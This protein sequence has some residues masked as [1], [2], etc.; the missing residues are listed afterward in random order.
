MAELKTAYRYIAESGSQRQSV[1]SARS[2]LAGMQD[3]PVPGQLVSKQRTGFSAPEITGEAMKRLIPTLITLTI[4]SAAFLFL[5]GRGSL[6]SASEPPVGLAGGP[7]GPKSAVNRPGIYIFQAGHVSPST[8]PG[9]FVGAHR[10]V[11]W[12]EIEVSPG[13]YNW[14][15]FDNWIAGEAAQGKPVALGVDGCTSGGNMAPAWIPKIL[16]GGRIIP[17]YWST[18]YRDGFR[19]LV[20][21][22]GERYNDDPRVEWVEISTGRDGENQP[23]LNDD[24]DKCLLGLGYT[25]EDWVAVVTEIVGYYR[26]AFPDK[27][28]MTQHYPKFDWHHERERRDIANYAAVLGVGFKG[29]GLTP[30]RDKMVCRLPSYTYGY[31]SFLEDPIISYS[32]TLPIG[33]ESYRFYLSQDVHVYWAL[34]SALDS[35]AD[36]IALADDVFT[37]NYGGNSLWPILQFT[38]AHVGRTSANTPSAWVALR[39]SGYSY[40]PKIGNYSYY[41]YQD[42]S[43]SAGRTQAITYRPAG[44]GPYEIQRGDV[45]AGQTYL[46]TWWQSWTTRRTDQASGNTYMYFDIDNR[47]LYGAT[48]PV[49]LTVTYYDHVFGAGP[50]TWLLEYDSDTGIKSAGHAIS[51][52]GTDEWIQKTFYL[53]DANFQNTM[54]GGKADF[55]ISCQGD[56]DEVI[57]FVQLSHYAPAPPTSTPTVT[58]TRTPTVTGTPPT[59]TSTATTTATPTATPIPT[60]ACFRQ[61]VAGYTGCTDTSISQGTADTNY[62]NSI[63]LYLKSDAKVSSLLRFDL[64]SVPADQ[65]VVEAKLRVYASQRD[66]TYEFFSAPYRVLRDWVESETTW[67]L[68]RTG[69][70]WA[71]PGCNGIGTDRESTTVDIQQLDGTGIW[72]EF[73][74]TGMAADWVAHPG[75]NHGLILQGAGPVSMLYTLYSANFW[76]IDFRPQL[77]VSYLPPAPT[78]TATSTGTTTLTPTLTETPT[79]TATATATPS[80]TPTRTPTASVTSTPDVSMI[81]GQVWNDLDGDGFKDAGEPGLPGAT[82]QLKDGQH[83]IVGTRVTIAGGEYEFVDLATDSYTLSVTYPPGF[84]TT[85]AE[86]WQI[87]IVANHIFIINFGAW[88]PG[89]PTATMTTT[90]GLPTETPTPTASATP[91]TD[92]GTA[93]PT[94]TPTATPTLAP[95]PVRAVLPVALKN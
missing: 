11:A 41:L 81:R 54:A 1:S 2:D 64:S 46:G 82:L 43:I 48:H 37:D 73:D 61:G 76:S 21:A 50:D 65:Q 27:P 62:G 10:T 40:W 9:M 34:L 25:S 60:T 8:Y 72:I 17:D 24:M 20:E 56:G 91:T 12:K 52:S 74:V 95:L 70:A 32:D 44:T 89:S 51:K 36:Y 58:P 86:T 26:D 84:Q 39:E 18:E 79:A 57:H 33:F 59:A 7:G 4:L 29:N 80:D 38:S 92:M 90:S 47:Y 55:R 94:E 14:S 67:N 42:D 22:F 6:T 63:S 88:V 93:T 16:C 75:E 28:L 13:V 66:K 87:S 83:Q 78:P 30:D 35:H 3:Q 45:Q 53:P 68:A 77:C 23:G 49:S 19:Q 31:L 85:T 71:A 69:T 15:Q 5:P